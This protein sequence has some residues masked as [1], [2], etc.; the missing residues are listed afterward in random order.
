MKIYEFASDNSGFSIVSEYISGGE[1]FDALVA[2]KYFGEVDVAHIMKQL[3]SAITYCHAHN[4]IHRDLKPE[5]ILIESVSDS[6]MNVKIIDFGTAIVCPPDK[7]IRGGLGTV[8][9]MAPEVIRGKCTAKCDVWSL[10]VIM[11]V[12]LCG[13]PPFNGKSD[14]EILATVMAGK[15]KFHSDIWKVVTPEAKDLITKMLTYDVKSRITAEQAYDHPWFK[16]QKTG[17]SSIQL[18]PVRSRELVSNL[19]GYQS[20]KK[21]QQAAMMFIVSQ[22]MTNKEK[23]DLQK[24]FTALDKNADGK[25]T[26][27]ELIAGYTK[28]LG[29]EKQAADAVDAL[30]KSAD[31]N[32]SGEI[33]YSG[34]ISAR[35]KVEFL[36]AAANKQKL[37]TLQNIKQAFD[38]FD[39][40][41]CTE[42]TAG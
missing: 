15:F 34:I 20:T 24:F 35:S 21:L 19:R 23:S 1:L 7:K 9:Y 18:D 38:M 40:V 29:D 5:N 22:L 3:L 2:Q 36:V 39:V 41:R 10:G 4:V 8:Y 33:D 28:M 30:L 26:R 17:Y 27:N 25:L 6:R 37:L 13:V 11:Y 16:I 42:T 14:D 12:M 31:V 32:M